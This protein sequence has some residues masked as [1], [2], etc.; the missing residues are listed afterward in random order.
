MPSRG[1]SRRRTAQ[2]DAGSATLEIAIVGP[3]LLL[4]I[5]TIVQAALWFYARNLALAAAQEGVSAGRGYG[6]SP[7][8]GVTRAR[9]FLDRAAQDSLQSVAVSSSGSTATRIRIEVRGRSLSVLPGIPGISVTQ[10]AQGPV[11][12]FTVAGP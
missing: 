12:R 11:E 1:R 3:A 6:A 9:A 7:S 2:G 4:L 5:F 10:S 8:V